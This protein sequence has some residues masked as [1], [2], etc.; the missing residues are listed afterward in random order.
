MDVF[1]ESS[2][3]ETVIRWRPCKGS[4][5]EVLLLVSSVVTLERWELGVSVSTRVSRKMGMTGYPGQGAVG[6]VFAVEIL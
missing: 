6:I 4:I 3:G 5:G 2:G 1:G